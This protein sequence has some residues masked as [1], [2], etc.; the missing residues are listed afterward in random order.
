MAAANTFT[1]SDKQPAQHAGACE[2]IE[3]V[4]LVNPPHQYLVSRR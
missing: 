3:Q 2:R 1:F 4:Q